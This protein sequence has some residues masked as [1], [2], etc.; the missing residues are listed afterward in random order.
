MDEVTAPRGNK[1]S[2]QNL[3]RQFEDTQGKLFVAVNKPK[4]IPVV[5]E[6]CC[7]NPP[8]AEGNENIIEQSRHLGSPASV[9]FLNRCDDRGC[10]GP[11]SKGWANDSTRA[12]HWTDEFLYQA[13]GAT[14]LG[15]DIQLIGDNGRQKGGRKE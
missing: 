11:I 7:P 9:F 4:V 10:L 14:I 12:L 6:E 1:E 13:P 5:R 8:R 2:G 3:F 15:V